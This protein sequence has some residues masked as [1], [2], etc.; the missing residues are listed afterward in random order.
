M[1]E[2]ISIVIPTYNEEK[3]ISKLLDRIRLVF[4]NSSINYEIIFI[5]DSS[6]DETVKEIN[7]YNKAL[8]LKVYVKYI[9]CGFGKR[10]KAS[11]LLLGFGLAKYDNVCMIDA[12]LQ[13]PPEAILPMYQKLKN[14]DVV[15]GNLDK[16]NK[17]STLPNKSKKCK[18]NIGLCIFNKNLINP[19][20]SNFCS[21]DFI[22]SVSHKIRKTEFNINKSLKQKCKKYSL[23]SFIKKKE[24]EKT[25]N[26]KKVCVIIPT[27]NEKENIA[28]LLDSLLD[29]FKTI[30]NFEMR[31]HYIRTIREK[32]IFF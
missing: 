7:K 18:S 29:I 31:K 21:S 13:Y 9:R 12:D 11:S 6:T 3:N 5:D 2:G 32:H 30:K 19:Q 24:F 23:D 17:I 16:Q 22:S 14:A 26:R 10:G 28:K 27:Y 8:P 15:I 20:K 25:I 4:L 1:P